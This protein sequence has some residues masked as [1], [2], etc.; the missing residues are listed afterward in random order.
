[1]FVLGAASL[2][3]ADFTTAS[4]GST[5]IVSAAVE[6]GASS[7]DSVA[8]KTV[9]PVQ[10]GV[11]IRRVQTGAIEVQTC[12]DAYWPNIPSHCLER[13]DSGQTGA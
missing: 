12:Q 6:P 10:S 1:M 2:A 7:T 3:A 5:A 9:R 8:V 11:S 13:V 4:Q